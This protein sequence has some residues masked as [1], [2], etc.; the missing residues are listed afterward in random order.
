[1]PWKWSPS[2]SSRCGHSC[3]NHQGRDNP[4]SSP[5]GARTNAGR[6]STACMLSLCPFLPGDKSSLSLPAPGRLGKGRSMSRCTICKMG[7]KIEPSFSRGSEIQQHDVDETLLQLKGGSA[8]GNCCCLSALPCRAT[9]NGSRLPPGPGPSNLA[10]Q[11]GPAGHLPST[12]SYLTSSSTLAHLLLPAHFFC[13]LHT[14]L[15]RPFHFSPLPLLPLRLEH[16]CHPLP[17]RPQQH[18]LWLP[19]CYSCPPKPLLPAAARGRSCHPPL[20]SSESSCG[21]PTD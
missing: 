13:S 10:W 17:G 3:P 6:P 4:L 7:R 5:V 19:C 21:S 20:Q 1:M 2:N 16:L 9:H 15:C 12:T 18:P 14:A 8:D 11:W